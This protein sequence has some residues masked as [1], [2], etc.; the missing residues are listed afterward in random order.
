MWADTQTDDSVD[1]RFRSLADKLI[2]AQGK[3]DY[4]DRHGRLV[5]T[6]YETTKESNS[7]SVALFLYLYATKPRNTVDERCSVFVGFKL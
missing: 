4:Y 1:T 6:V 5:R 2:E 7:F 3:R